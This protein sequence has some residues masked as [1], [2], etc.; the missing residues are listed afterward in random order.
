[1]FIL[2]ARNKPEAGRGPHPSPP[3]LFILLILILL[4]ACSRSNVT[5]VIQTEL[6]DIQA[7]LYP[8]KAPLT[9]ANFIDLIERGTYRDAIFY[10]TVRMDN[11]PENKTRIEVIQGGLFHDSLVERIP[12]I[13]HETTEMTGIHHLDGTISMARME[14]GTASSEF[15]ICIGDQP[16]LDFNG[17]RNPDLQGFS[18]FGRVSSGMD[19]IRKIQAMQDSSQ[20]LVQPVRIVDISVLP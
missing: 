1:M 10:R 20:Y 5:I 2:K 7:E 13:P 3:V 8:G 16:E 15:F 9:T 18:A 6:G 4:N 14:P 11:Q 12:P 19:I 17:K